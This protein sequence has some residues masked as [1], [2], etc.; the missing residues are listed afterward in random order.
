MRRAY[1]MTGDYCLL[2]LAF[3]KKNERLERQID[4]KKEIE[5]THIYREERDRMI[6]SR[7][8]VR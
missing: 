2:T 5:K 4:Q 6:E 1:Q 3:F 8:T 7:E